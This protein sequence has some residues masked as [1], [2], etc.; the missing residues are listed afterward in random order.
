MRKEKEK[1][2]TFPGTKEWE[3]LHPFNIVLDGCGLTVYWI[4]VTHW[5]SIGLSQKWQN[6]KYCRYNADIV[7]LYKL[8]YEK[9]AKQKSAFIITIAST[10][11]E[12]LTCDLSL[13]WQSSV[14][15]KLLNF[16]FSTSVFTQDKIRWH[17]QEGV[18]VHMSSPVMLLVGPRNPGYIISTNSSGS[19]WR[20]QDSSYRCL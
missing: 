20:L 9:A 13:S 2:N 11:Y 10:L 15:T 6:Q 1:T 8:P 4:Q 5:F 14:K 12:N 7:L 16:T 17:V 3:L 19:Q 18:H